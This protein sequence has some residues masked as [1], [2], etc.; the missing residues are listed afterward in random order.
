MGHRFEWEFAKSTN[1]LEV[2]A[3]KS[4][5]KVTGN[6]LRFIEPLQGVVAYN[7][8]SAAYKSNVQRYC[9][10]QIVELDDGTMDHAPIMCADGNGGARLLC[11]RTQKRNLGTD[12][13]LDDMSTNMELYYTHWDGEA[14]SGTVAP[15]K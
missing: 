8:K 11:G 6:D 5:M 14:F 13:T 12:V 9:A 7:C 2:E 15:Y 3:E 1:I 10:P 4:H